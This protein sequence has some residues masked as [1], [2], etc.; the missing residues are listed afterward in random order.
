MNAKLFRHGRRRLGPTA[1]LL[2]AALGLVATGRAQ[3]PPRATRTIFLTAFEVKGATTAEK[4][5][6]P[7]VSPKDLSKGYD[8]KAPGDADPRAPARWEVSSY[9]FSPSF[10]T[11]QRGD[12]VRLVAFVVNG[13]E[14]EVRVTDPSG[15]TVVG[16]A[17][18]N[19]GRQY[20]ME[21][22]AEKAGAYQLVC[23]THAPTML[24]TIAVLP[25]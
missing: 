18:W 12:T 6:P 4:L 17:A 7:P 20:E 1:V 16:R 21:F 13:D 19:R 2:A 3:E 14:H 11:V 8:F 15:A 22:V 24:A 9:L 10:V 25:R 5:P 23:S